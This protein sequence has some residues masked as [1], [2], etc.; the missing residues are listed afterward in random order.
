MT[1]HTVEG[2]W[3]KWRAI[4]GVMCDKKVLLKLK[5]KFYRVSIR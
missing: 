4:I 3:L 1:L 5:G 2:D